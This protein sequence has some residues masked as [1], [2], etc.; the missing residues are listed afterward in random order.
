M[1]DVSEEIADQALP[2]WPRRRVRFFFPPAVSAALRAKRALRS[3][4]GPV[5]D[6]AIVAGRHGRQSGTHETHPVFGHTAG[7]GK[8]PHQH[9]K[10]KGI[11]AVIHCTVSVHH[12]TG[13]RDGGPHRRQHRRR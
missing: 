13:S 7:L 5:F 1:V 12:K 6:T 2:L 10:W 9:S 4:K 3:P 11:R 8:L